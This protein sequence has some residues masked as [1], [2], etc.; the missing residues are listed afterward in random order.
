MSLAKTS[1]YN[2][3]AVLVRVA[4]VLVLNKVLAVYVGPIGYAVIGQ[5][6]NAVAILTSLAG[7][8]VA[9]GVTKATA[10]HFDNE[11]KQKA[12]WRT[13]IRFS[14]IASLIVAGGLMIMS[15]TMAQWLLHKAEMGGVFFW[16][17]LTLPALALNNLLLAIING[18]K[19]IGVYVASNIIGSLIGLIVTGMLTF[20]MG[21]YG[22][23]LAFAINPALTL[24]ATGSLVLKKKWFKLSSIWGRIDS[25][26][27]RELAGFGVMA[28]TTACMVPLTHMLIRDYLSTRLGLD[29][30]GYWQAVWKISDIYLMLITST[31]SVYYLPRIAEI[32]TARELRS[33]IAKTYRFLLPLTL[34]GATLIF[35]LRD[36]IIRLLFTRDFIP[37]RE[38]FPWQL[39][40]DVIK[41]SAWMLGYVVIGR[42]LVKFF[43]AKEIGVAIVFVLLTRLYVG[44][45]GLQGVT[46]A[47]ALTYLANWAFL[48]FIVS[49]EMRR[50]KV[51]YEC[52]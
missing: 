34:I 6:Q 23:L 3:I 9:T 52:R 5:F 13:A 12:V 25:G 33:E 44:E 28:V 1:L 30:A 41:M 18:K 27:F 38:L 40:G 50:M 24:L 45:F 4:T 39:A 10:Q 26:A 42:G 48:I 36:F 20:Y 47:Y 7:G 31:L 19:E 8:V 22:A 14:L 51:N 16:L 35:L 49:H 15:D 2:G 43:V 11:A 17:A 21:L 37:M 32:R 29:A 46:T